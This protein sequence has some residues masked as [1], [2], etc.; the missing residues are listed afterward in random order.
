MRVENRGILNGGRT[1]MYE[2]II[3]NVTQD[4]LTCVSDD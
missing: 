3:I 2:Q 1:I 4:T